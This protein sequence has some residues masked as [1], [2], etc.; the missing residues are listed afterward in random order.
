MAL[1]K[2]GG[3]VIQMSGSIAGN[4]FARNRYGYYAR[5][6]TKP[7]NP[8]TEHQVAVRS[9]LTF[10]TNRWSQTLDDTKRTA[11][12]DYADKVAMT[13]KLGET[14]F[15]SGY[16]HYIRSNS[17]LRRIGLTLVDDGPTIFE[18][19]DADPTFA[20]TASELTQNISA[21]FDNTMAWAVETGGVLF[22]FQGSPQNAQR[23]F[24]GGPWRFWTAVEGIDPG[25]AV[26]PKEAPA[27]FAIAEDQHQWVYA[28]ILRADGRLSQPFRD[29]CYTGA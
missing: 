6:R 8:N 23:N 25:G 26:T 7:I 28:R 4:T 29:D 13:N 20:I 10:L 3:G 19:P 12:N 5:E 2:Y 9:S 22:M 11:W 16:N 21:A 27:V 24:F 14:V 15:L 18:L 17:L 1:I